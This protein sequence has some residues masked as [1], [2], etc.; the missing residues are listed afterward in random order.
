MKRE[1]PV[2]VVRQP[3]IDRSSSVECNMV[4]EEEK[5]GWISLYIKFLT[6]RVLPEGPKLKSKVR[7]SRVLPAFHD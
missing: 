5:D 3:S 1:V 6:E 7:A 2:E 4:Q